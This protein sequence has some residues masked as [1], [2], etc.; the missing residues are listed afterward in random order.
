MLK[1]IDVIDFMSVFI[2]SEKCYL[3]LEL[4]EDKV[5]VKRKL[6]I[7]FYVLFVFLLKD[8]DKDRSI[9]Y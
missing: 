6:Y 2:K 1:F 7:S 4:K 5:L 8:G 9:I 3:M